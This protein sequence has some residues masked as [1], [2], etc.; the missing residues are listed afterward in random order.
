MQCSI[1]SPLSFGVSLATSSSFCWIYKNPEVL[2]RASRLVCLGLCANILFPLL[3]SALFLLLSLL[4]S[5]LFTSPPLPILRFSS[6]FVHLSSPPLSSPLFPSSSLSYR[7]LSFPL[8]PS[9]VLSFSCLLCNGSGPR[10]GWGAC[11]TGGAWE[12]SK[13][14]PTP[15]EIMTF[16]LFLARERE[17]ERERERDRQTDG[18]WKNKE[19]WTRWR[20]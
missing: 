13:C 9:S 1:N 12:P 14:L 15:G 8:I 11:E 18:R 20:K 3:S 16:C 6:K 17:R 10:P 7:L 2:L 5:T 19:Q 4:S